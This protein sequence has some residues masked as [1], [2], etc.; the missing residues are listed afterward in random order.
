M[1]IVRLGSDSS[2][3]AGVNGGQAI[4][5]GSQVAAPGGGFD[6]ALGIG[7]NA[8]RPTGTLI[9]EEPAPA[10]GSC[11]LCGFIPPLSHTAGIDFSYDD[12]A[13]NNGYAL[14]MPGASLSG[15][16]AWT[17]GS[18]VVSPTTSGLSVSAN[19]N[20]GTAVA[21]AN[22][23]GGGTGNVQSNFF[24]GDVVYDQFGGQYTVT[25]VNSASGAITSLN[26]DVPPSTTS[27]TAP[28]T[29][30]YALTYGSGSGAQINITWGAANKLA[31]QPSGGTITIGGTAAVSCAGTPT[32]SFASTNGI[33]T[34]C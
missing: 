2:P 32:A 12:F 10:R 27:S 30:P 13:R 3:A 11:N 31:L 7:N 17:Q 9:L 34:H 16:G 4:I 22:G 20:V 19:G 33:V 5:I 8:V 28:S 15:T 24:V 25:G 14:K 21:I 18:S 29:G 23:G 26:I 6:I 1:S